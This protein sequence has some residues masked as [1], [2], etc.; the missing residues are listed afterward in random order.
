MH[1]TALFFFIFFFLT[2]TNVNAQAG[3]QCEAATLNISTPF[4]QL[5]LRVSD[6]SVASLIDTASARVSRSYTDIFFVSFTDVNFN[7]VLSLRA[8]NFTRAIVAAVAAADSDCLSLN[9]SHAPAVPGLNVSASVCANLTS[10]LLEWRWAATGLPSSLA[11]AVVSYPIF[12]LEGTNSGGNFLTSASDSVLVPV[13]TGLSLTSMYP[14]DACA[15]LL[16]RYDNISGALLFPKDDG[17][18]VK[19]LSISVSSTGAYSLISSAAFAPQEVGADYTIPYSIAVSTFTGGDWRDAADVYGAWALDQWWS[20]TLISQRT[21]IP[22]ILKNGGAGVVSG[23][24]GATGY[25]GMYGDH[26]IK[27]PA[28]TTA[29]RTLLNVPSLLMTTYG[30]ESNGTWAGIFY[31]PPVPSAP[32]WAWAIQALRAQ[33]DEVFLLVSGYWW[34]TKRQVTSEGPGFDNTARV[35]ALSDSLLLNSSGGRYTVDSFATPNS[36]DGW[37]GVSY[38][39]CHGAHDGVEAIV[40]TFTGLSDLGVEIIS[41]DQEIG[42]GQTAGCYAHNHNHTPGWGAW[43]FT[44]FNDTLSRIRAHATSAG[45]SVGLLTEQSCELLIPGTVTSYSRQFAVLEWPW[46]SVNGSSPGLFSYLYH[47]RLPV[48]AAEFTQGAGIG[49]PHMFVRRTAY[50]NALTRGLFP[51]YGGW[52]VIVNAS[53]KGAWQVNV[54]KAAAAYAQVPQHWLSFFTFGVTRRPPPI[55]SNQLD[56][57]YFIGTPVSRVNFTQPAVVAGAFEGSSGSSSGRGVLTVF[58]SISDEAETFE[59][60]FSNWTGSAATLFTGNGTVLESWPVFTNITLTSITINEQCGVRVL[61][62]QDATLPLRPRAW[63]GYDI[64]K[65]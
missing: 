34:V 3:V 6:G 27:M 40:D 41:F 31:L 29:L 39:I 43:M 22:N 18:N 12:T 26:L 30:W 8:S 46:G 36:S 49:T 56:S 45:R 63:S 58:A 10:N 24:Q 15:Q 48:I 53:T 23:I 1:V 17:G 51:I 21:D 16:A 33:G 11:I 20:R 4:T 28:A 35:A 19:Q 25:N 47:D 38:K 54:T 52:E 64:T 5:C 50:A 37:R 14:G 2:L 60:D 62:I 9:F 42:G 65:K 32:D 44:E 7:E 61:V 13:S 57:Y 59:V 55:S